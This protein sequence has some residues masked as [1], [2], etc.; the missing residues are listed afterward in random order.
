MQGSEADVE[1]VVIWPVPLRLF[2]R[3]RRRRRRWCLCSFLLGGD[4]TPC[5]NAIRV[6]ISSPP[7]STR[8]I[9]PL[10]IAGVPGGR[11]SRKLWLRRYRPTGMLFSCPTVGRNPRALPLGFD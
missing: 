3:R 1:P 6:T 7:T 10:V 8:K 5:W 11:Y 9:S 2:C 4:G